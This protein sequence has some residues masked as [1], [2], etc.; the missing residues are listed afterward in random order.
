MLGDG[1]HI[2]NTLKTGSMEDVGTRMQH[3][4]DLYNL[5]GEGLEICVRFDK[6]SP[7]YE[8]KTQELKHALKLL[9]YH[10]E[11]DYHEEEYKKAIDFPN[12]T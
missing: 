6:N 1:E 10:L 8:E 11:K 9:G 4:L 5:W 7:M 3:L 12:Q 2:S